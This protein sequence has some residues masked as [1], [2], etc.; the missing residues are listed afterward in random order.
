MIL[1]FL[2]LQKKSELKTFIMGCYNFL[3]KHFTHAPYYHRVSPSANRINGC[4][5][6]LLEKETFLGLDETLT[7]IT[8]PVGGSYI[9]ETYVTQEPA[10]IIFFTET[11]FYF[12]LNK[13]IIEYLKAIG[14]YLSNFTE[15]SCKEALKK[16]PA[17]W[18]ILKTRLFDDYDWTFGT[19][20]IYKSCT[21]SRSRLISGEGLK[22]AKEYSNFV[23][24]LISDISYVCIDKS[25]LIVKNNRPVIDTS[26]IPRWV[27]I[28]ATLAGVLVIK[29]A[30]K[31]IGQDFDADFDFDTDTPDVNMDC[32]ST[33]E[34]FEY[35][36]NQ[37]NISFGAQEAKLQRSGGGLGSLYVTI[38]KE[39]DSSN[40]FCITDGTHTIH[41]VKGG[42]NTIK[43]D[44][45]K[46][47][48]PKLKG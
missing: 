39:P 21:C 48:L 46:Y 43:I 11:T 17:I 23:D 37:Y 44:G 2:N 15:E 36:D 7:K 6:K 33:P 12:K 40:L 10:G 26:G 41:N 32:D 3:E 1:L 47:I 30:L 35:L 28:G 18:E 42:T 14:N 22:L 38:T 9:K 19:D 31:S 16:T 45:I 24:K 8:W 34:T 27:K 20:Y 25:K 4:E 5:I 29:M 13:K